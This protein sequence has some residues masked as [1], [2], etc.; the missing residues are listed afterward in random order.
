MNLCLCNGKS[1]FVLFFWRCPS[2][3]CVY[4]YSTYRPARM[5]FYQT[6]MWVCVSTCAQNLMRVIT[7]EET[8]GRCHEYFKNF[9]SS[10][11]SFCQAPVSLPVTHRGEK[12]GRKEG[13]RRNVMS[14][15]RGRKL[16]VTV[17]S[18]LHYT[19]H[20]PWES[21]TFLMIVPRKRNLLHLSNQQYH[22]QRGRK[23]DRKIRGE[24]RSA[25]AVRER[26]SKEE[27]C[28][29]KATRRQKRQMSRE[30]KR[31]LVINSWEKWL[32]NKWE[33]D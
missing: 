29:E 14:T 27:Q 8:G 5:H 17:S 15:W 32:E 6:S 28:F 16:E 3:K 1:C 22:L 25:R 2:Q 18:S 20:S 33:K 21:C 23:S 12:R 26:E 7:H 4:P 9:A 24:R 30:E 13:R 19:C 10:Q 11:I 31:G